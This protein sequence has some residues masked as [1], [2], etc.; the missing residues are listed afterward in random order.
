MKESPAWDRR[1]MQP[2]LYVPADAADGAVEAV[3]LR[4]LAG[5]E[6]TLTEFAEQHL[7]PD[8]LQG[9]RKAAT[10]Q[11]LRDALKWWRTLT[12]D[13]S[14]RAVRNRDINDFKQTLKKQRGRKGE[15]LSAETVRQTL[16]RIRYVMREA[17]K[18]QPDGDE[19]I[20]FLRTVPHFEL[21][22]KTKTDPRPYT[23]AELTRILDCCELMKW[24]ELAGVTA[25]QFWRSLFEY[26]YYE[27]CRL[28]E[29]LRL[30]YSFLKGDILKIPDE[31]AKHNHGAELRLQ[32]ESVAALERLRT[33][34]KFIFE[35][36]RG[37]ARDMDKIK[38][39]AK[40]LLRAAGVYEPWRV[41]HGVRRT[42]ASEVAR[43]A[44]KEAAQQAM[45]HTDSRTTEAYISREAQRDHD[46]QNKRR[47]PRL[48]SA[49]DHRQKLLP[50]GE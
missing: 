1:S 33:S 31:I 27:G 15:T 17:N 49:D 29:T 43:V 32:P 28:E 46:Y 41:F 47:L 3:R 26:F 42:N 13:P 5:P 25:P 38:R 18:P 34:R 40:R 20:V 14:L 37:W 4:Q 39:E 2:R 6:L 23:F 45:R 19:D 24:P 7:I 10:I 9:N 12:G 44:G 50:F 35:L 8:K 22:R 21:P 11:R 36:P 30:E 48:P 16:M